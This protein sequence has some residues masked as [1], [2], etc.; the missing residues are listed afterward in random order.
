MR[1][2][3]IIVSALDQLNGADYIPEHVAADLIDRVRR[4]E[5]DALDQWLQA[6]AHIFVTRAITQR[7]SRERRSTLAPEAKRTLREWRPSDDPGPLADLFAVRYEVD[8]DHTRRRLGDMTG[9][10]CTFVADQYEHRASANAREGRMF[11]VLA[12]R[13]GDRR[14]RDVFTA[15]QLRSLRLAA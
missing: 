12:E 13:V 8:P 11:R 1:F 15:E 2:D 14:V 9:P 10:D 5:P 7:L 4:T 3:E 6:E